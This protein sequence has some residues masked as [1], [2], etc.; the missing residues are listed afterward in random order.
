M[1]AD[2]VIAGV[3]KVREE[4]CARF[5]NDPK[6]FF[7]FL[8]SFEKAGKDR[9]PAPEGKAEVLREEDFRK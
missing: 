7:E 3:R 2:P 4:L 6:R 8:R 9:Y 1:K 5:D